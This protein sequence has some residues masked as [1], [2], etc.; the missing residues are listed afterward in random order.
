M[1][2]QMLIYEC[3]GTEDEIRE[4]FKT[5]NI[6]G[7][8]LNDQELLNAIYSGPF[9]T[10]AREEFSNSQNANTQKWSAYITGSVNRQEYLERALDRV[11]KGDIRGYMSKHRRDDN[12]KELKTY[13]NTV[14]DWF[15]G[16]F[17]EVRSEMRGLE[18][19][20][21]Y[22]TYH[23]N[24]YN[25]S[26]VEELVKKYY[27]DYCV[28]KKSGIYEYVLGG[29]TDSKLLQIRVFDKHVIKTVY[30]KQTSKAKTKHVSNC[31][32]CA[33][34]NDSNKT[35]IWSL[36]EMDAD[37]VTAWSKGGETNIK[38]CQMLCKTHNRAKDNK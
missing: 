31:P 37:H 4:W 1:N 35:R 28:T 23:S 7:V 3:E 29:C 5:I 17:P 22:E 32:L 26:E 16:V 10:K 20:R 8:P 13:F 11:S 33:L 34:G 14:I 19:S 2:T 12:I 18:W 25:P 9:V 24:P 21:L 27:E 36:N 38:N 30:E 15:S 6:A